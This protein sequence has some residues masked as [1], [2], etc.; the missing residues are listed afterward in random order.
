MAAKIVI[1]Q[2]EETLPTDKTPLVA[3]DLDSKER[4]P[5]RKRKAEEVNERI[6]TRKIV[7]PAENTHKRVKENIDP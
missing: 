7:Q 6:I 3:K 5:R 2:G 1:G 4:C